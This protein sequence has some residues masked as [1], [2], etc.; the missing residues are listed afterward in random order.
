MLLSTA[1][2]FAQDARE[3]RPMMDTAQLDA[4]KAD[5]ERRTALA[6]QLVADKESPGREFP[7]AY[8]ASLIEQLKTETVDQLQARTLTHS[9]A[10]E[11]LG[12]TKA[13]LT[14]TTFQQPCRI[15]DTRLAGGAL[16]SGTPRSF[17]VAGTGGG[18]ALQGGTAGG[19]GVP[20]G[21]TSVMMNFVAVDPQG[22]G[23][24]K[25]AAFPNAIP[26]TGSIIN[27]QLLA[28]PLN[29]ANG[30]LF[31]ICDPTTATCTADITLQANG[32][33]TDVVVDVLGYA[34]KFPKNQVRSFVGSSSTGATTALPASPGCAN[35]SG[36][37]I[38][39][40]APVAGVVHVRA[41]V[42]L[43]WTHTAG[44]TVFANT[45]I[46]TANNVCTGTPGL[47]YMWLE[48]P[49]LPTG[50]YEPSLTM[51]GIFSVPVGSTTFY[52]NGNQSNGTAEVIDFW[53]A[54]MTATFHPN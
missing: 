21:A 17:V 31:P 30:L 1:G 15:I 50:Q 6:E 8:R 12:D 25:G 32:A 48:N 42:I 37:Q 20:V 14:Y 28:P 11:N 4:M 52:L 53:F 16:T 36:G 49:A 47:N 45:F 51:D 46:A 39:V 24:L 3:K 26:V 34:N 40:N 2:L 13:D 10:V 22:A 35:Y 38:T 19:C 7:A 27:Y 29:I 33:G 44:N 18:F 54:G 5:V 43:L 23:N 41:N 9:I